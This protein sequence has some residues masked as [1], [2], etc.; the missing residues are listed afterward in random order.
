MFDPASYTSVH[1]LAVNSDKRNFEDLLKKTVEAIFM[2]KS[3]KFNGFFGSVSSSGQ[4]SHRL[5]MRSYLDK[6]D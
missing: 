1:N 4:E 2:F 5:E 6:V 3:L